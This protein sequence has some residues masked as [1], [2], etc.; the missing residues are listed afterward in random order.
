MKFFLLLGLLVA[1]A[2]PRADSVVEMQYERASFEERQLLN[3]SRSGMSYDVLPGDGSFVR[4]KIL[5]SKYQ[6]HCLAL[7]SPKFKRS[8]VTPGGRGQALF[9][10]QKDSRV[11]LADCI[12][13]AP[14]SGEGVA[15]AIE[16]VN[17]SASSDGL[18]VLIMHPDSYPIADLKE[19][20]EDLWASHGIVISLRYKTWLREERRLSLADLANVPLDGVAEQLDAER[21][22][23]YEIPVGIVGCLEL[24]D[25][26]LGGISSPAGYAFRIPGGFVAPQKD[27]VLLQTR[28]CGNPDVKI[29][30][31]A[32]TDARLIAHEMGH[33]LG[34]RHSDK[35]TIMDP[36]PLSQNQLGFSSSELLQ[37]QQHPS[38]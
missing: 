30:R 16:P 7:S 28:D 1:C 6:N 12:S 11:F 8:Q 9:H 34:L 5:D 38:F 23:D 17:Q 13:W 32:S 33:Y 19:A 27:M 21:I 2:E 18:K 22:S 14:I 15:L 37:M 26:I 4:A 35:G 36:Q 10:V 29:E 31:S 3:L 20:L 25:P 24:E